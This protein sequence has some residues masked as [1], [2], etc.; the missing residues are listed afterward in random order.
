MTKEEKLASKFLDPEYIELIKTKYLASKREIKLDLTRL[1]QPENYVRERYTGRRNR[2]YNAKETIMKD[3]KKEL[4][5]MIELAKL[6]ELQ[7]LIQNKDTVYYVYIDMD[8]YLK[9]PEADSVDTKILK[10]NKVIRP[11]IRPDL[12]NYIKLLIDTLHDVVFDDDKRVM[13]MNANKYYSMNPRT[14]MRVRIDIIQE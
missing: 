13:E 12:D 8:F 2:F 6:Q 11:S 7:T 4:L 9:T 3:M 10:E 14:E 1:G 5:G